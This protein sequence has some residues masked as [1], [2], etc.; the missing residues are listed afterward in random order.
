[1]SSKNFVSVRKRSCGKVMSLHLS[2]ILF[3]GGGVQPP[4]TPPRTDTRLAD[5]PP[6]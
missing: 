6:G 3:T 4:G 2:V 5:T 1:M